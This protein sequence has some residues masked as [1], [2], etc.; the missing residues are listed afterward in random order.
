MK[1]YEFLFILSPQFSDEELPGILDGIF[2]VIKKEGGEIKKHKIV[3]RQ[4]LA[5]P[6]NHMKHGCY[7]LV[8]VE[9]ETSALPKINRDLRLTPEILRFDIS[10]NTTGKE[11]S[12]EKKEK[13]IFK[14]KPVAVPVTKA[15]PVVEAEKTDVSSEDSAKA[16]EPKKDD[17][18]PEDILVADDPELSIAEPKKESESDLSKHPENKVLLEDLDKK[19]DEILNEDIL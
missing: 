14:E 9:T 7:V 18:V 11:F 17:T 16:E 4:A 2:D 1:T 10:K 6:I 5:Y 12:F 13:E 8:E 3:G 19:L 15:T